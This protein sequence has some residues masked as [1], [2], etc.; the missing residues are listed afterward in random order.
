MEQAKH[1]VDEQRGYGWGTFGIVSGGYSR[2]DT[3]SHVDMSSVNLMTGL[4]V[5][6][7]LP[8]GRLT[9]GPFFEYGNGL[10]NTYNS[11]SSS[12]SV[13][14]QGNLSYLGGGI[15]ARLD[16][17]NTGPGHGYTEGSA[18]MGTLYNNYRTSDLRDDTGRSAN[19]N[20]YSTYYAAHVGLG[21]IWNFTDKASLD[22]YGKYFW[23]RLMGTDIT[24]ST[25]DP[26]KFK[27]VDSNRLRFGG[28][29]AYSANE[30]VSPYI[31]AAWEHEFDGKERSTSYGYDLRSPTL[32]GDTGIGELGISLTPSLQLP[33]TI[34]M[35]G[36][37]Y[38]GKREGVTGTLQLFYAF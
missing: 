27:E 13:H 32:R 28:R 2:Y 12:P 6:S 37:V 14:S 34:T 19:Y 7:D 30:Y 26:V 16:F 20:A 23:A 38:I 25:G 3:G 5:R 8:P 33:L 35:G 21:Y 1:A 31:G 10:Y 15:L 29:L 24:L 11:F 17:V 36:Q 22:L 9:L 4:S 18:R